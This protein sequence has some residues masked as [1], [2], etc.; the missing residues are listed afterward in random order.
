[1]SWPALG[2]GL[3]LGAACLGP[4]RAHLARRRVVAVTRPALGW[5]G[6]ASPG[7]AAV[8][9]TMAAVATSVALLAAVGSAGL[10]L[11]CPAGVLVA[12]R[13]ARTRSAAREEHRRCQRALPRAADLVAA[14]LE[15]GAA[16]ADALDVVRR[17]VGDPL[18]TRL[19]PVVSALRLGTDPV[20]AYQRTAPVDADDMVEALVRSVARAVESGAR[21]ADAATLV[22]D[23][24]RR[25]RRWSAEAAAR[26]AGV[27]AVGP[28][29]LCYLPAFVLLGVV[30]VVLAVASEALGGLR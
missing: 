8:R 16:P 7:R 22:A 1:M 10:A 11:I 21:L 29:V 27:L 19:A 9:W 28:L 15:V 18:D 14:C 30:P 23:D 25:R 3:A 5:T 26:R 17:A 2:A 12:L 6:T 13:V 20:E 4:G 24:A